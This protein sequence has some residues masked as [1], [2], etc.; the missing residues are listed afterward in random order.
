MSQ[1][2]RYL[3][4]FLVTAHSFVWAEEIVVLIRQ[5]SPNFQ[6]CNPCPLTPMNQPPFLFGY[7]ALKA[8]ERHQSTF[9]ITLNKSKF[10][11]TM[12][13][14]DSGSSF[15]FYQMKFLPDYRLRI[16]GILSSQGV[17]NEYYHYFLRQEDLFHYLGYLPRLVYDQ[18][19]KLFIASEKDGPRYHHSNSYRL[20]QNRLLLVREPKLKNPADP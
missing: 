19:R 7:S 9:R 6:K 3:L 10:K 15:P 8:K 5:N 12:D 4:L 18:E 17:S 11:V 14:M 16:Y 1:L 13:K 2:S 20:K